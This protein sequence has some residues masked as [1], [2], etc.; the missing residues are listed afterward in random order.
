MSSDTFIWA[1]YAVSPYNG[2]V[3][4]SSLNA[5]FRMLHLMHTLC[6]CNEEVVREWKEWYTND[7]LCCRF[8]SVSRL[9]LNAWKI[10]AFC[11]RILGQLCINFGKSDGC[12][13]DKCC[14]RH[15]YRGICQIIPLTTVLSQIT[16]TFKI[17]T[18]MLAVNLNTLGSS[19]PSRWFT[20]NRNL[21]PAVLRGR[22]GGLKGHLN[23]LRLS[24]SWLRHSEG[25][26]AA[27]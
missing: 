8:C 15:C 3:Q 27:H 4:K 16:R 10:L 18:A 11:G 22:L 12:V 19:S 20:Q 25:K 26:N 5:S 1:S 17:Y 23:L 7:L 14:L 9:I 6:C 21:R 2:V 24:W 13:I